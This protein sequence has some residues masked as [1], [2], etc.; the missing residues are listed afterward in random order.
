MII[1]YAEKIGLDKSLIKCLKAIV[2]NNKERIKE[3]S[4]KLLNG[5]DCLDEENDLMRLAVVLN[6]LNSTNEI[7]KAHGISDDIFLEHRKRHKNMV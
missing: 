1:T 4:K 5:I 3:H 7:Y 2:Q 6:C